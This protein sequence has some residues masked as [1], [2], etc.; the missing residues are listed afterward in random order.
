MDSPVAKYDLIIGYSDHTW[1]FRSCKVPTNVAILGNEK[2]IEWF[3]KNN[4]DY[5]NDEVLFVN[6]YWRDPSVD[7]VSQQ[8]LLN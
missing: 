8:N 1:E 5:E 2:I 6:V 4:N 7:E 3:Q